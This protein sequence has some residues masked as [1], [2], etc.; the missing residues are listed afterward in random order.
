MTRDLVV[1]V[2]GLVVAVASATTHLRRRPGAVR[3]GQVVVVLAG[4]PAAGRPPWIVQRVHAV[5]GAPRACGHSPPHHSLRRDGPDRPPHPAR[6]QP[7]PAARTPA[8]TAT[9]ASPP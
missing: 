7:A 1:V 4:P 3:L 8:S 9:T 2:A 6:R 5:P